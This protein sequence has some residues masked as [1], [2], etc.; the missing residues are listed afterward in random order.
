M[1]NLKE[2]ALRIAHRKCTSYDHVP[3]DMSIKYSFAEHHLIDFAEALLAEIAK[4]NKPFIA[5]VVGNDALL[6]AR[7]VYAFPPSAEQIENRVA[8]ACAR[9]CENIDVES[10]GVIPARAIIIS[11][12]CAQ[13][14][15]R[16]V[17]KEYLK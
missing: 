5:Y 9:V 15:R 4:E 10:F 7:Q 11:D 14:F 16:G 13:S 17:W 3:T 6:H 1:E 8:E 12:H 2:I